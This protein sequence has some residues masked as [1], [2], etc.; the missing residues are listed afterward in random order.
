MRQLNA[1]VEPKYKI[2]ATRQS[3]HLGPMDLIML[4]I[5]H[6]QKGLLYTFPNNTPS[7]YSLS[8]NIMVSYLLE[9]LK[10]TLFISLVHFY[11]LAGRFTT[12]KYPKQN[13]CLIFVDC[14]KG[15]GGRVILA[16]A[17]ELTVSDFE[18]PFDVIIVHHFLDL[19]EKYVNF[20]GYNKALLS[21]QVMELLD[22]VF[23]GL[24]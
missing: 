5:D 21:I 23:V 6:I 9:N 20:N 12:K 24:V 15:P 18:S 14:N 7:F 4:S 22:G 16:T 17:I 8:N 10:K 19:G 3:Y 13:V 1:F 2:E 11:P